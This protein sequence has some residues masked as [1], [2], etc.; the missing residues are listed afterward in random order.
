MAARLA[1]MGWRPVVSPV[2]EARPVADAIIDL[3]G[4][5][6]LAFTS[7]HAIEAFARLR[8]ARD[9]PTF[10]VG[11][12][13]AA[14]ARAAGF[15]SVASADG[16]VE[17]LA[18][19]IA[20]AEPR[21]ARVLHPTA[22]EPAADLVALL[23]ERGVAAAAVV[24]YATASTDMI[25]DLAQ[26]DAILIHSPKAAR[27]VAAHLAHSPAAARLDLYAISEAAAAPVRG[28]GARSIHVADRPTEAALLALLAP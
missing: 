26:I 17:A 20:E 16:D 12:A 15:Q 11:E 10:T 19:L 13:S 22:A 4:V 28:L 1:A 27:A 18:A 7:G 6:A 2:L 5:D 23:A 9:L 8:E 14:I 3:M 21:P 24:V 25:P